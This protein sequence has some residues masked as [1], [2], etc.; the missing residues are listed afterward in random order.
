M[1]LHQYKKLN[2]GIGILCPEQNI[3]AIMCTVRSIKN[4]YPGVPFICV[5]PRSASPASVKE[6]SNICSVYKGKDTITSLMNAAIRRGH[7]EWNLLVMEG[8][9]VRSGVVQKYSLFIDQET[10][11]LFPIVMDHNRKGEPCN[12]KNKFPDASLN[13][14]FIHQKTFKAVGDFSDGESLVDSRLWWAVHAIEQGTK[15]KAIL[16][17]QML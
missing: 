3:G 10:D 7:K 1:I 14:T 13:G 15:F 6:I 8:V 2:F 16:G 17:T 9:N 12:I 4:N 11:V 5:L